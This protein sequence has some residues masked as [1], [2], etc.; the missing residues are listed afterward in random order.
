MAVALH[1]PITY[2][3]PVSQEDPTH[4]DN[5]DTDQPTRDMPAPVFAV[6]ALIAGR[7]RVIRFIAEG[8]MGAVYEAEDQELGGHVALKTLLSERELDETI[9]ERFRREIQLARRV[10][11]PN[12]CRVY[13]IGRSETQH[14]DVSFLSMELLEGETLAAAIRRKGRLSP[15]EALPIVTQIAAGLD[16]AHDAG[17][18]HR[19]FKPQNVIL[20]PTADDAT[21]DRAVVTDFGIAHSLKSHDEHTALTGDGQA[22]G[23]PSYMSPEQVEGKEL[24]PASDIYSLGVVMYEMITGARPFTGDSPWGV[25]LKRITEPP[26]TPRSLIPDLDERW[27]AAIMRCLELKPERRVQR[28]PEL[29]KLLTSENAP[30]RSN[31]HRPFILSIVLL[32]VVMAV[33]YKLYELT[34]PRKQ[35]ISVAAVPKNHYRGTPVSVDLAN[36]DIKEL[37]RFLSDQSELNWILAPGVEGRVTARFKK[38]P[39]DRILKQVLSQPSLSKYTHGRLDNI[40]VVGTASQLLELQGRHV[41]YYPLKQISAQ[42]AAAWLRDQNAL[43]EL[44][45]VVAVPMTQAVVVSDLPDNVDLGNKLLN[46]LDKGRHNAS[47]SHTHAALTR[48]LITDVGDLRE[49]ELSAELVT[50]V[51][52]YQGPKTSVDF[53]ERPIEEAIGE[54]ARTLD[55]DYQIDSSVTGNVTLRLLDARTDVSLSILLWSYSYAYRFVDETLF[56]YDAAKAGAWTGSTTKTIALRKFDAATAAELI[57]DLGMLSPQGSVSAIRELGSLVV[58]DDPNLLRQI[59]RLCELIEADL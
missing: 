56:I 37:F 36:A 33:A 8:G 49:P 9:V 24:T 16:A 45:R 6:G 7:Y 23:T 26:V 51:T 17:V 40:M 48:A 10:T 52:V 46:V 4:K 29:M 20:V 35:S 14:G 15:S 58:A 39:W 5:T 57:K 2:T 13:D 19:D 28:A 41:L 31:R 22:L 59:V 55:L 21:L 3:R 30:R 38:T 34:Q 27:E 18:I 43:S 44:G 11:H 54:L 1:G 50:G 12:V 42:T 25:A 53:N 32:I 47:I